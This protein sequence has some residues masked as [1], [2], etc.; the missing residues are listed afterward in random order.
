MNINVIEKEE[1]MKKSKRLFVLLPAV[2]MALAG[3]GDTSESGTTTST[4]GDTTTTTS[5]EVAQPVVITSAEHGSVTA[6]KTEAMVGDQVTFSIS[7]DEEYNFV[8]FKVNGNSVVVKDG[9]AVVTMVEGG[10]TATLEVKALEYNVLVNNAEHGKVT[11][12]KSKAAAGEKVTFT[13]APDDD[14]ELK[15]LLINGSAVTVSGNKAEALM[16]KEG[17]TVTPSFTGIKHPVTIEANENG[18]VEA[19]VGSA[20]TGTEIKLVVTPND[21][22]ELTELLVNGSAVAVTDGKAKVTM[23]KEGLA[24][25]ATFNL[26]KHAVT[27]A[28]ATNGSVTAD[29]TETTTG[30]KVTFT[31]TPDDDYQVASFKVNGADVALDDSG[32]A[33]VAMIKTGLNAEATFVGIQHDVT[34]ATS[35]NGVVTADKSTAVTGE[36]VTLTLTPAEGYNVRELKVNDEVVTV[37]DNKA[38]VKMVKEGL[39]VTAT[40]TDF[41]IV[42]EISETLVNEVTSKSVAKVELGADTTFASA[43]PL[44]TSETIFDLGGHTLTITNP[45]II[46]NA[47]GKKVTLRNGTIVVDCEDTTNANL[48]DV[49]NAAEFVM[50]G[51]TLNNE[52]QASGI[53]AALYISNAT[54]ATITD[55]TIDFKGNYG[56]TTNNVKGENGKLVIKNSTVTVTS[57]SDYDC[58]ALLVNTVGTQVEIDSSVFTGDRQGIVARTG[59]WT[60]SNTTAI[61]TNKWLKNSEDNV[62]TNNSY[63]EGTWKTGNE[64]PS[65]PYVIGDANAN[66]YNENVTVTFDSSLAILNGAAQSMVVRGDGVYT[67]TV[68]LDAATYVNL[69]PASKTDDN[70]VINVNNVIETTV[71]KL[72]AMTESDT[73]NIYVVKGIIGEVSG[74]YGNTTL[75]DDNG[76]ALTVYGA[77]VGGNGEYY[78][79]YEDELYL[80]TTD[81]KALSSDNAGKYAI[82]M[83]TFDYYTSYSGTS[84]PELKNA[85]VYEMARAVTSA[86]TVEVNDATMGSATLSKTEDVMLGDVITVTATPTGDNK[87]ATVE[88]TDKFGNVIDVTETMSFKAGLADKVKVTFV[89]KDT[90]ITKKL[91]VTAAKLCT[92]ADGAKTCTLSGITFT[93][94]NG[95]F[96]DQARVYKNAEITI[97]SKTLKIKSIEFT[98]TAKGTNKYG[99]GCFTSTKGTYTYSDYVGTWVSAETDG[100]SSLTLTAS[101]NQVRITTMVITVVE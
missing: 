69:G 12:D 24:V 8:D 22:Y 86:P 100:S 74:S 77:Y 7:V 38:V 14:Y 29:K 75:V 85:V 92:A 11:A 13:V 96:V 98:C 9:K 33:E 47:N 63:L 72:L 19:N 83:G 61:V 101:T 42:N 32:K 21:D 10:L 55:S 93:I 53:T 27:I 5:I 31:V 23:V 2:I 3:C 1:N 16:V 54:L 51:V 79:N 40:F 95:G 43:L 89:D 15:E 36:D 56:I 28:T 84:T 68:N 26:I 50:S 35:E 87:L 73:K 62:T 39:N 81:S 48:I 34:I 46:E 88:V 99:P 65:A 59:T 6:D 71:E 37:T 80:S 66:A 91:T 20:T 60:I 49:S 57:E 78:Y 4:G 44:A 41:T 90:P 18:K 67:T 17:L 82:M 70:A 94:S 64:V 25:S 30:D 45:D 76:K 52:H 97:T 58:V